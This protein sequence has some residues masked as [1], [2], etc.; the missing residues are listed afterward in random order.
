MA[1]LSFKTQF[2]W[3]EPTYFIP[4]IWKGLIDNQ[5]MYDDYLSY[6]TMVLE[7]GNDKIME[8]FIPV[9]DINTIVPK[10]HT[11]REDK[12]DL[13][14]PGRKIH[15]AVFNRTEHRFQFAPVLEC[16][17][18]Q[19]ITIAHINKTHIVHI[20]D[21]CILPISDYAICGGIIPLKL[22]KLVR[23]DGFNSA[24]DFFR[25]FNKDFT[26]KI[27]HWTEYKY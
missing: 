7:S 4:K 5:K 22:K 13:W 8:A 24:E 27:V 14:K 19:R 1:T 26:G 3:G 6:V 10:I 20:G 25:Y 23:N 17:S 15:M 18:V 16:K 12:Y 21:D 11:I 9:R 2:P